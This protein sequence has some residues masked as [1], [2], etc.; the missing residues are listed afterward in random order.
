MGTRK[1]RERVTK[2]LH[3]DTFWPRNSCSNSLLIFVESSR[4]CRTCNSCRRTSDWDFGTN[5]EP[6]GPCLPVVRDEAVQFSSAAQSCLTLCDPVHCSTPGFPVLHH[7]L[8]FAQACVHWVGDAIQPSH[9][10][11]LLSSPALNLSQ[12][13]GLFSE[14]GSL[15]EV[16]R[17]LELQLQYQYLQWIFRVD[18][19]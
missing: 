19:L 10:L 1:I 6:N 5:Q 16:A 14:L 2:T 13:W 4:G 12:H 9:P 8:E 17:V 15:H 7:L 11:F 3:S 18:F